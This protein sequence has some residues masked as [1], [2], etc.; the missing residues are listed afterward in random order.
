VLDPTAPRPRG[1]A[2][3]Y[4]YAGTGSVAARP[5]SSSEASG[6]V[7]GIALASFI[8]AGI[9]IEEVSAGKYT[10]M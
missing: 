7:M 6:N 2:T 4:E 9:T 10:N 3:V 1:A 8:R 5:S